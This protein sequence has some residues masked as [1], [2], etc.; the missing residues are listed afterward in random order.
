[1]IPPFDGSRVR[2]CEQHEAHWIPW[3]GASERSASCPWCQRDE[4]WDELED[5]WEAFTSGIESSIKTD[6]PRADYCGD[7]NNPPADFLESM[8]K[9]TRRWSKKLGKNVRRGSSKDTVS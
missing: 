6:R 5:V 7:F 9:F 2:Y 8:R 4:Y 3:D 1:M